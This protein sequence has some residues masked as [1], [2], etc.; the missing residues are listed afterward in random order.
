MEHKLL[1]KNH[2]LQKAI[3]G[4]LHCRRNKA[5][6]CYSTEP[7]HTQKLSVVRRN[8]MTAFLKKAYS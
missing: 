7:T 2:A 8:Y 1:T 5:A 3:T 4:H 6:A